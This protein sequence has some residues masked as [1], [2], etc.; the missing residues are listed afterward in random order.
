MFLK[1]KTKRQNTLNELQDTMNTANSKAASL[2]ANNVRLEKQCYDL[3]EAL[4]K[5]ETVEKV[6]E[7]SD[8][9]TN[10]ENANAK[11]KRHDTGSCHFGTNC[12]Y[13]H[14]SNNVCKVF[15]KFGFCN[16]EEKCEDRHP[17]GVCLQW[18]RSLCDRGL[19]CFYQHP[20]K[21][22]GTLAR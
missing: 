18:R 13:S 3:I 1:R 20:E 2:E 10:S 15:S 6:K 21:E 22:Y 7:K 9:R 14:V 8:K 16:D 4:D 17:T 11:C 19:Q 5:E 12:N